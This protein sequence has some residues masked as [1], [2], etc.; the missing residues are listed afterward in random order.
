VRDPATHAAVCQRLR[1]WWAGLPG[2][3]V[4]GIAESPITGP[5]GNREFL[6]AARH[7]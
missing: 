4:L 3:E 6:L 1:E 2:W 5:E 7:I